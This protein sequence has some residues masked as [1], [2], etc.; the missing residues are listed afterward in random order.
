M[1]QQGETIDEICVGKNVL[2]GEMAFD[3]YNVGKI[4]KEESSDVRIEK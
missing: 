2:I 4:I 1:Y 3:G